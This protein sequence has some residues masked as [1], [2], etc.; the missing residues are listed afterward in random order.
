MAAA[1]DPRHA[2]ERVADALRERISSKDLPPGAQLPSFSEIQEQYG[3][4]VTTA[5]RALRV[6][7]AEGLIEGRTGRGNFVRES[8]QIMELTAGYVAPGQDGTWLSWAKAA[9]QQGMEG[10]QKLV[11]VRQ[12]D[13]P[14]DVAD[15]LRLPDGERVIV[16]RR[17]MLLDGKPVQV[18][19]SYYPLD[20]A[21]GTPLSRRAKIPGGASRLLAEMG[22]LSTECE[23]VVT[24]RMPSPG[25]A[26]ALEL[27]D[28]VPVLRLF[29]VVKAG[30]RPAEA[31]VFVLAAD[32]HRLMYR[33]PAQDC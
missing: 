7:K 20:I 2:F 8:R 23:E 19:E 33:L 21:E 26:R 5:Q 9:R 16:R 30:D 31:N 14:D 6:L 17:L 28:G 4:A 18:A 27:E 12:T 11:D 10:T 32:R 29:R 15:A 24:A 25:E 1:H 13:P 22:H 3:V